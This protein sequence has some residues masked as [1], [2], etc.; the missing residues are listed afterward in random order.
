MQQNEEK[1]DSV[2]KTLIICRDLGGVKIMQSE[3]A[4]F[5]DGVVV[6]SDD[7]RVQKAAIESEGVKQAVFLEKMESYYCV[8]EDVIAI[9]RQI[10]L[11]LESLGRE[12]EIPKD[13]LYWV[14]HCEGGDTSQRVMDLLLLMRSYQNMIDRF[15]PTEIIVVQSSNATWEDE[16]L[17]TMADELG[18][19]IRYS[20]RLGLIGWLRK[21]VW[22]KW[23]PLV[24]GVYSTVKIVQVK[25]ANLF[26]SQPAIDPK[27]AVM[28]QLVG[29]G[30]KHLN[31]TQPLLK[32]INDVGLQGVALG[33]RLGPSAMILRQ[34]G[35]AVVELETWVSLSDLV[36]GWFRTLKSWLRAKSNIHNFLSDDQ[37]I[38][39]AGVLRGIL[40]KSMRSFYL[41]ELAGRYFIRKAA[42]GFFQHNRPRA[43]RPHSIVLPVGVIPYRAIKSIDEKIIVFIQ[44]G[45]PYN[46]PE[47]ITDSESQI[48]RDKV[49]FCSCGKLHRNILLNKGFLDKNVFIT[50]LHWIE[51]ISDFLRKFSKE[52]SRKVL[53][54]DLTAELY[55]LLD[56]GFFLRGYLTRQE[57]YLCLRSILEL[58]KHNPHLQIMIKP[59][60]SHQ[61]GLLEKIIFQYSLPNVQLIEH[62][63]L[64]YHSLNAA[65][66]LVT[67]FSTLAVEGMFLGVPTLGV[68]LDNEENFKC[69]GSAVEYHSSLLSVESKLQKLLDDRECRQKW[70]EEM[71]ERQA[72]YFEN[73]GLVS[74]GRPAIGVAKIIQD[75]VNAG[76]NHTEDE[77]SRNNV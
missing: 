61:K 1:K 53:G 50:G 77:D 71:K 35:I 27:K 15:E 37:R 60:P 66:V 45:W 69:Y 13:L 12:G 56:A 76:N 54:L 9:I 20:G 52:D 64:P 3:A 59:H 7:P 5:Q 17:F 23:R 49:V 44:G 42:K 38:K 24:V 16:L 19:F 58:A 51:Q 43:L 33:W 41:S 21:R 55:V 18:I 4:N 40:V 70:M 25:L 39:A 67:K 47:P 62:S 57:R 28:V 26:R 8:A 6:V 31:H 34:E 72:E 46:L 65:D 36:V 73:H 74:S 30:K 48:P 63:L 2:C 32:A 29:T 75:I 11:W 10:N 68:I 14:M 22:L